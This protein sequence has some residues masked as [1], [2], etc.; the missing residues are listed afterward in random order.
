MPH[1]IV[2]LCTKGGSHGLVVVGGDSSSKGR[3][4]ES[5]HRILDGHL[6]AVKL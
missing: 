4:F 6:F 5:R 2:L 1:K 3:E